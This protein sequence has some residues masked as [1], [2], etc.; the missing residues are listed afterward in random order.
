MVIS[1]EAVER[2]CREKNGLDFIDILR[3]FTEQTNLD[4]PLR[5][6]GRNIRIQELRFR[7]NYAQNI[8]QP[9]A[10]FIDAN[11]KNIVAEVADR[12]LKDAPT[13]LSTIRDGKIQST[14]WFLQ[15]RQ[16]FL[17]FLC[18]D[19][20]ETFDHPIGAIVAI[21]S[22]EQDP[23]KAIEGLL[24]RTNLPPLM[25]QEYMFPIMEEHFGKFYIIVHDGS[26]DGQSGLEHARER[27][28]IIQRSYGHDHCGLLLFNTSGGKVE[29][30][31]TPPKPFRNQ[32]G[33]GIET[34]PVQTAPAIVNDTGAY[35]SKADLDR[36]NELMRNFVTLSLVPRLDLRLSA[37]RTN[38]PI[39]RHSFASRFME[40]TGTYLRASFSGIGRDHG[41]SLGFKYYSEE[42]QLRQ[43]GDLFFLLQRYNDAVE[44]FS[45]ISIS[46]D[47]HPKFYAG[48]QFMLALCYS[49][50]VGFS[51][52][53]LCFSKAYDYYLRVPGKTCR[54]L[55]TRA[56]MLHSAHYL[57]IGE[58]ESAAQVLLKG[59]DSEEIL[60]GALLL[61]QSAILFLRT[62]PP[63]LRKFAF[64]MALAGVWYYN[65]MFRKLS[66]R[67]YSLI[68]DIYTGKQWDS[69]EEHIATMMLKF[70][71]EQGDYNSAFTWTMNMLTSHQNLAPY[72]QKQYI[73]WVCQFI[74]DHPDHDVTSLAD[75][76]LP[77]IHT[78]SLQVSFNTE[79]L[80]GNTL[81]KQANTA[82]WTE[83]DGRFKDPNFAS[84]NTGFL[85]AGGQLE[86]DFNLVSCGEPIT[87]KCQFDN[88]L[89][90]ELNI[91]AARLLF[92]FERTDDSCSP[93]SSPVS[94][95]ENSFVLQDS[96]SDLIALSLV[97][98]TPGRL[99]IIGISWYL[100]GRIPGHKLIGRVSLM[101]EKGTMLPYRAKTQCPT[102]LFVTLDPVPELRLQDV[103]PVLTGDLWTGEIWK[104][105]WK[106]LT[107]NQ[108]PFRN[109]QITSSSSD[110]SFALPVLSSNTDSTGLVHVLDGPFRDP[111]SFEVCI[112]PQ[113]AG[114]RLYHVVMRYESV[115][116]DTPLR[117][118]YLRLSF[119]VNVI[120]GLKITN[121]VQCS[122]IPK[123]YILSMEVQNK[124]EDTEFQI[125]K[126]H[127]G[128]PKLEIK[129]LAM[130]AESCQNGLQIDPNDHHL[131][132]YLINGKQDFSGV[133]VEQISIEWKTKETKYGILQS[134]HD[135]RTLSRTLEMS[136]EEYC[137]HQELNKDGIGSKSVMIYLRNEGL[138]SISV[139]FHAGEDS[140]HDLEPHCWQSRC[141]E[142]TES[143]MSSKVG[144]PAM[145]PWIW[146]GQTHCLIPLLAPGERVEIHTEILC[147]TVGTF[148]VQNY[149]CRWRCDSLNKSG[150]VHGSP[151]Y[152][153][154]TTNTLQ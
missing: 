86:E 30:R 9:T 128:N 85:Q 25:E 17:N 105:N 23:L 148:T 79:S 83:L 116:I 55:A 88:P 69:I 36:I 144:P 78:E 15:Y 135:L 154:V 46:K 61:E 64:K 41:S 100:D 60:R 151:L 139:T 152:L 24:E 66:L 138:E 104:Q 147:F 44:V 92:E 58:V 53:A 82:V 56:A 122:E 51:D 42:G 75:F 123:S 103:N 118:R 87:I 127:C 37:M 54:M 8:D 149:F 73:D 99:R 3:P 62:Q 14:Q 143:S 77:V 137:I 29:M 132:H 74:K 33:V 112:N 93:T 84:T 65:S 133:G 101:D 47:S 142:G 68:L 20:H 121:S 94:I 49:M 4:L 110:M 67:C 22:S 12:S 140:D 19:G 136:L 10:E 115:N 32:R 21:S 91:T 114:R 2:V 111:V 146:T 13:N 45:S 141:T 52:P 18:F 108:I 5:V 26:K 11:L 120:Q 89:K 131:H 117:I 76:S 35:L 95:L 145:T 153:N 28:K 130:E 70:H 81:A 57:S 6:S 16:H 107:G 97:P 109:L 124:S 119:Q 48:I 126:V 150:V 113:T 71:L 98:M 72:F 129:Q 106:I 59:Y 34:L 38:V 96:A 7:L 134:L 125:C 43:L 31:G 63:C 1:D 27:L 102:L 50:I 90:T 40:R 39:K 80:F